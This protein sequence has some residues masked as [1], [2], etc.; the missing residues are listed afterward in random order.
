M[1]VC[2]YVKETRESERRSTDT[3]IPD[4]TEKMALS[5][6]TGK[7]GK[8]KLVQSRTYFPIC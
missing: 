3:A 2:I 4:A 5:N 8:S 7:G 1:Y 6:N